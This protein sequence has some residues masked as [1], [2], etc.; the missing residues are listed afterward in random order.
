MSDIYLTTPVSFRCFYVPESRE[1]SQIIENKLKIQ[2]KEK[3]N[4][5][6][7]ITWFWRFK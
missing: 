1:P 2:K 5:T 3:H 6:K 7:Q 4:I